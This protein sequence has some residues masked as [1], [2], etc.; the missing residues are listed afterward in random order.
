MGQVGYRAWLFTI[1][2]LV[3]VSGCFEPETRQL[4]AP[5]GVLRIGLTNPIY[6]VKL[7]S[8]GDVNFWQVQSLMYESL[9][10]RDP[11]TGELEP[12]L[13]ESYR[14]SADKKSLEFVLRD[15]LKWSDGQPLSAWDV[16]F[17]IRSHGDENFKSMYFGVYDARIKGIRV[18]DDRK[19]SIDFQT[20]SPSNLKAVALNLLIY[21][22][23]HFEGSAKAPAK[24][25]PTS[26]AFMFESFEPGKK[27]VLLKRFE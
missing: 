11:K 15:G 22:R 12:R 25:P 1:A 9:L 16:E 18:K 5:E 10:R 13:A 24:F 4:S 23:F 19:F 26:G 17:T 2:L 14:W 21:P 8:Q 6:H 7:H 20:R 27:L 3:F